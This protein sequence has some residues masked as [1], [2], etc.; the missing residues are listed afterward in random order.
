MLNRSGVVAVLAVVLLSARGA[1]GV[2]WLAAPL[3]GSQVALVG[4]L[5]T[6]PGRANG[7]S[8]I[9]MVRS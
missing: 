3:L 6:R 5:V 8:P 4:A 9:S 7:S 1:R 2:L